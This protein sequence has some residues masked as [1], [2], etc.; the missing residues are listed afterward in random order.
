MKAHPFLFIIVIGV[1]MAELWRIQPA[2]AQDC[3]VAPISA[4]RP[5]FS[6]P[7]AIVPL[8]DIQLEAGA[9]ASRFGNER[10]YSF[11]ELLLRVPVT[12]RA[13]LRVGLPSYLVSRADGR[14]ASGADDLIVETKILLSSGEHAAYA[15]LLNSLL[16]TGSR[17]VAEHRF[18]PGAALAADFTLSQAAEV[19]LNLGYVHASD[20]G[21]R[22]D[23]VFGVSSLNLML[24][25]DIGG[26]AE[27]YA[28]NPADGP[29]QKYVDGGF[30]YLL[31]ARTQLDVSGGVGLDNASG[32]PDYFYAF[33][34]SRLF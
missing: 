27:V 24:T 3:A 23:Q 33:G 4:D 12:E 18:Q 17:E 20:A 8:G 32:G 7:T 15:L 28:F 11:G 34:I 10:D 19:T 2:E 25:P 5:G 26:F 14:W 13:E 29:V 30:T 9:T 22:Y 31:N 6:T 21:E 1:S 16:P